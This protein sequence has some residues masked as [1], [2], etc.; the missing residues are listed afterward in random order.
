MNTGR[1][2]IFTTFYPTQYFAQRL[3]GTFAD[4]HCPV[5]DGEDPIFWM[6]DEATIERYQGADL[7]VLNG[8]AFEKWVDKVSLPTSR[9]VETAKPFEDSWIRYEN[10][11][12][13]QH[14]PEGAHSHEGIDGHTW[15]APARAAE[16]VRALAKALR[17]RWPQWS[18]AV[19]EGEKALLSDLDS[20]DSSFKHFAENWGDR[21]LL[22]SHPAYN[23]W[24]AQYGLKVVN[25]TLDPE[26]APDENEIAAVA[27]A[28]A[29]KEGGVLLWE[30]EPV[31]G[32]K[33]FDG[34]V[35]SMVF[36]P[37][38]MRGEDGDYLEA[39]KA[40]AMRLEA[41]LTP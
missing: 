14:G 16:Q 17:N 13:H 27:T 31:D 6:P 8:A 7:I 40:N 10:A 15:I 20:L 28:I 11:V 36:A 32:G 19:D 33:A 12:V 30:S 2:Q 3:A 1:P 25:V 34:V 26:K 38:E 24:A 39:M 23:Y 29:G 4:V 5:P 21:P 9:V 41:L 37:C 35:K 22:A 18:D